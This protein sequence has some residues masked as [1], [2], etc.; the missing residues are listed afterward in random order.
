M[1]EEVA[2]ERYDG[3]WVFVQH[4]SDL[5][6]CGNGIVDATGSSAIL[7]WG[8]RSIEFESEQVDYNC[9]IT[10]TN[11]VNCRNLRFYNGA[12][13]FNWNYESRLIA[14]DRI[15]SSG[16]LVMECGLNGGCAQIEANLGVQFPCTS[17]FTEELVHVP[18]EEECV[19]GDIDEMAEPLDGVWATVGAQ[20]KE[21]NECMQTV[22]D[23]RKFND[24]VQIGETSS[25]IEFVQ[26]GDVIIA[27]REGSNFTGERV[28]NY[29]G[30]DWQVRVV[31]NIEGGYTANDRMHRNYMIDASC[32]EGNCDNA[33]VPIPCRSEFALCSK[34]VE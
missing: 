9:E 16:E 4:S 19:A 21:T 14:D 32:V 11:T 6:E 25:A 7:R 34:H 10:G 2:F 13:Y 17:N 29:Y 12:V 24:W 18:Y 15:R 8:V 22:E 30:Q 5:D 33:P 27:E 1:E 28:V 23:L 31:E 3:K 20:V 26:S